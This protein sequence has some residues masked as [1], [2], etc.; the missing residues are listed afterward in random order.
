MM[1]WEGIY[2]TEKSSLFSAFVKLMLRASIIAIFCACAIL[3]HSMPHFTAHAAQMCA[4]KGL[5]KG[6]S[7]RLVK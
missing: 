4:T 6:E 2:H 5:P 1:F 7:M 3:Q